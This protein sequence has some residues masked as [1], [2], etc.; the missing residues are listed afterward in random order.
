MKH[1]ASVEEREPLVIQS[2]TLIRYLAI[3]AN[4]VS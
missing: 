4:S 1:K 3:S 2:P